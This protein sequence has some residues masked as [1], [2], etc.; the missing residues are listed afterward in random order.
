[1]GGSEPA[2]SNFSGPRL[3]RQGIWPYCQTRSQRCPYHQI[4]LCSYPPWWT[5]L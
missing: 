2:G 3:R 4:G 1:M 5:P